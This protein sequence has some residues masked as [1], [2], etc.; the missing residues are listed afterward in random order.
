MNAERSNDSQE[1]QPLEK[2]DSTTRGGPHFFVDTNILAYAYDQTEKRR[3]KI[4]SEL[5][6]AAFEGE[7]NAYVSNQIL[8]ELF[9]V[10]T[11]KVAK[12]LS[13]K[14]A[15]MIVRGFIDSQKWRK[16]D[17]N[18]STI[19]RVLDDLDNLNVSF[20]DLLIAE[21]MKEAGVSLLYTENTKDFDKIPWVS[22]V[23]P[24]MMKR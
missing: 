11:K 20:W 2:R 21:T 4:C 10:L 12:P 15:S 8:G 16:T 17:Y 3:R 19:R 23:N 5:V 9:F 7:S 14:K 24:M 1:E 22:P 6:R 18:H 13:N